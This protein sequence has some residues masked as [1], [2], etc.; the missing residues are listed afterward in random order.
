MA[1]ECLPSTK[2]N[3]NKNNAEYT[4]MTNVLRPMQFINF[5]RQT[6]IEKFNACGHVCT[7]TISWPIRVECSAKKCAKQIW[8]LVHMRWQWPAS[9]VISSD[10]LSLWAFSSDTI[11]FAQL[12][13]D[14]SLA[15]YT[16]SKANMFIIYFWFRSTPNT[17]W[18]CCDKVNS[19]N[20]FIN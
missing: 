8:N 6:K 4:I 14:L 19:K 16:H 18:N 7:C 9:N 11:W 3:R 5:Q 15:L 10:W 20:R 12:I 17:I 13:G 1:R 2:K